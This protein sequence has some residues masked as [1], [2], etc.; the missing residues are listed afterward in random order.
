MKSVTVIYKVFGCNDEGRPILSAEFLD[1]KE[2]CQYAVS[3]YGKIHYNLPEVEKHTYTYDP[4][5]KL[6]AHKSETIEP[7]QIHYMNKI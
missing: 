2:A 7:A 6:V 3:K 1:L 4:K 5:H